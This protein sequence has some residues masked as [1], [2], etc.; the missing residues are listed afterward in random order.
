M[1]NL[2]KSYCLTIILLSVIST[3]LVNAQETIN[4]QILEDNDSVSVYY[5]PLSCGDEIILDTIYTESLALK[6]ERKY[7]EI[8]MV[9]LTIETTDGINNHQGYFIF[10]FDDSN[11]TIYDCSRLPHISPTGPIPFSGSSSVT[12]LNIL[13]E[14]L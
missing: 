13:T 11:E 2:I 7:P 12:L 1:S 8:R 9:A 10:S 4:W 6:V 14:T 5:A 3:Q